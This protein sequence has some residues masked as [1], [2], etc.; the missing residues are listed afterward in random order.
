MAIYEGATFASI[1]SKTTGGGPQG[2]EIL[3]SVVTALP[4]TADVQGLPLDTPSDPI[5]LNN[6]EIVL[7]EITA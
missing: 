2:C 7:L 3:Y 1:A 6:G 5:A 4:A